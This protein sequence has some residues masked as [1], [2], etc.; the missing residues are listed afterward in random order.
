MTKSKSSSSKKTTQMATTLIEIPY[1]AP[2]NY[3]GL[4]RKLSTLDTYDSIIDTMS[5]SKYKTLLTADAPIYLKT[6]REFWENATLERQG[7]DII[8]INC[9]LMGKTVKITPQSI[10]E[11]FELDDQQGKNSFLKTNNKLIFLIEGMQMK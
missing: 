5:S 1:K 7:E 2:P 9:S 10:S 6:Q 4:L 8:A 3:L 11:V